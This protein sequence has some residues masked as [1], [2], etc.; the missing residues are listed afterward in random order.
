MLWK[1]SKSGKWNMLLATHSHPKAPLY[2][3][4]R[5]AKEQMPVSAGSFGTVAVIPQGGDSTVWGNT[6]T[7]ILC[8]SIDE[9][10]IPFVHMTT[11]GYQHHPTKHCYLL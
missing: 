6:R 7:F 8:I 1:I 5:G 3:D 9:D 11:K 10:P 2:E 4:Q